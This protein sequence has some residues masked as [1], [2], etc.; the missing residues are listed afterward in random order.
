M[1]RHLFLI[2]LTVV[3]LLPL[4]VAADF[5]SAYLPQGDRPRLWLTQNRL[6]T[7]QSARSMNTPEWQDFENE[8]TDLLTNVHWNGPQCGIPYMALMYKLTGDQQYADRAIVFMDDTLNEPQGGDDA[9]HGQYGYLGIG[10][11][12]LYD[13]SAMT[14]AKKQAYRDKMI[15]WSDTVWSLYNGNGTGGNGQDTDM[16]IETGSANLLMGCAVYGDT[17]DAE[18]MLNRAWWM[19]ERGQG[20]IPPDGIPRQWTDAQPVR[21]WIQDTIQGM[22]FPGWDYFIGDD[23]VGLAEYWITLRTACGYDIN[24]LE[25][26]LSPFWPNVIR[27]TLDLTDPPRLRIHHTGDWQDP[28]LISSLAY[29]YHFL[30]IAAFE[31][32]V[33]GNTEWAGYARGYAQSVSS[34]HSSEFLEFFYSDPTKPAVDPYTAGLPTIRYCDGL[35]YLFFRSDWTTNATWGLFSGQGGE[36]ADH[37]TQDVGNFILWYN[38]DFLTKDCRIYSSIDDGVAFNTLS[39]ENGTTWGSPRMSGFDRK[40]SIDRHRIS[41]TSPRFAYAMM[42]A[43][44]QWDEDPDEWQ[45]V[46]R[47]D[48]YRRHFFTAGNYVVVFDRLRTSDVGWCK[49]RLRALTQ[50]TLSGTTI[51]QLSPDLNSKLLHKTLEPATCSFTLVDEST[52]WNGLFEDWEIP[53]SERKW[54]YE[55]QPP[56]TDSVDFLNV[57]QMGP[58]GMT[59][60]DTMQHITGSGNSGVR[61]GD[62]V[63]VCATEETLRWSVEYTVDQ[64]DTTLHHLVTDLTPGTYQLTINGSDTDTI[65]VSDND[66]TALFTTSP[67]TDPMTITLTQT[68]YQPV[69]A[70]GPGSFFI[71]L[72]FMGGVLAGYIRN[73]KQPGSLTDAE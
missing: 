48:S 17:S 59:D 14:P 34:N 47:I 40:A 7:L 24:V 58:A 49:Y 61:I 56:D 60:F 57:M 38:G 28:N 53:L 65:T 11:D 3:T 45:A 19:W 62:W 18:T 54:Q 20:E 72:F 41:N 15:H 67:D 22:Y 9:S 13:N 52:A 46:Q 16:V 1:K 21:I 23:A 42:Q 68:G 26:E 66:N 31:S 10:Y 27:T 55:I 70:I 6:S 4:R 25:P 12:W 2:Y 69:P 36:P 30:A 5:P 63:V 32:D 64:P 35:D 44:D 51:T 73:Q 29:L 33:A 43:D 50:P 8:C 37:Q 71:L 39:I